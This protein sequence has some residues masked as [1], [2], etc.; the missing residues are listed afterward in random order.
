MKKILSITLACI[1]FVSMQLC[2]VFADSTD[3]LVV[4]DPFDE[5]QKFPTSDLA[6]EEHC[7]D[8]YDSAFTTAISPGSSKHIQLSGDTAKFYGYWNTAHFDYMYYKETDTSEKEFK[9]KI[10]QEKTDYHTLNSFGFLMNCVEA[11]DGKVS[12]YYLALEQSEIVLYMLKDAPLSTIAASGTSNQF[13]S[14]STKIDSKSIATGTTSGS[15]SDHSFVLKSSETKFEIE[16]NGTSLFTFDVAKAA[17]GQVPAGYTGGN[18]FGFYASYHSHACTSLSYATMSD[19]VLTT[20][21]TMPSA[22]LNVKFAD[23][24]TRND[25]S[26]KELQKTHTEKGFVGQGYTVNPT[27]ISKYVYVSA[28]S[29]LKGKFVDG[30]SAVTLFYVKPSYTVNYKDDDGNILETEIVDGLKLQEYIVKAKDFKGYT[31]ASA[32]HQKITLTADDPEAVID[33]VYKQQ[34]A[35][36]TEKANPKTNDTMNPMVLVVI[37]IVSG[38]A[39]AFFLLKKRHDN[40]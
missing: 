13:A 37:L 31:L 29:N 20:E 38:G 11:S 30:D 40:K 5:K 24:A 1:L 15:E 34:K 18:D 3:G 28:D 10:K 8:K 2:T 4:K 22:N 39:I 19:I 6:W 7:Q 21:T 27:D 33:F 23:Y 14:A 35:A 26:V 12:G 32:D 16:R 17:A 25:A 36:V 9:F